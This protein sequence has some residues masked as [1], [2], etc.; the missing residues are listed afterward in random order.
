MVPPHQLNETID[1]VD[2]DS[3]S[4]SSARSS[5]SRTSVVRHSDNES[6]RVQSRATTPM[7][8]SVSSAALPTTVPCPM[9]KALVDRKFLESFGNGQRL[10]SR[11]ALRFCEAHQQRTAEEQ[12]VTTGYP[13]IDWNGLEKRLVKLHDDVLAILEQSQ[14]STYR[15]RLEGRIAAGVSKSV[16]RDPLGADS[17]HCLPGYYGSRGGR[18]MAEHIMTKLGKPLRQKSR[19]DKI[20]KVVGMPGYVQAVLV[21]EMARRLVMEDMNLDIDEAQRMM[22]ESAAIGELLNAELEEDIVD[23]DNGDGMI[24]VNQDDEEE[25]HLEEDQHDVTSV[26]T[27]K[28]RT[29]PRKKKRKEIEVLEID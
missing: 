29:T 17:K 20:F 18:I 28:R 5:P 13:T 9:C 26:T 10:R 22:E 11:Q 3:S 7:T 14:P 24:A 1:L 25:N 27:S 4:L 19:S 8:S 6:P 12:W 16:L 23:D 2:D 21:P 15:E